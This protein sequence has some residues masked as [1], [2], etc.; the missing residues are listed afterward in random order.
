MGNTKSWGGA[1]VSFFDYEYWLERYNK[2]KSK[3]FKRFI[4]AGL[5]G[6]GFDDDYSSSDHGGEKQARY[7][8]E[9]TQ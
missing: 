1:D 9:K 4:A 2:T 8:L 7:D 3:G 6:H 5:R